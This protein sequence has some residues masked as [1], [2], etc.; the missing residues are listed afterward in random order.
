MGFKES[1]PI[2]PGPR[3]KHSATREAQ[4]I[5]A[6]GEVRR[7][8]NKLISLLAPYQP[9]ELT[10][11]TGQRLEV[12][13]RDKGRGPA[14]T[15]AEHP[16]TLL[17]ASAAG[18]AKIRVVYGSVDGQTP[19]GMSAGDVPPYEITVSGVGYVFVIVTIDSGTGAITSVT[20]GNGATVP[21]NSATTFHFTIGSYSVDGS[22]I[23]LAQSVS[24]SL[25]F[26]TCRNWYSDPPT[27]T[28]NWGNV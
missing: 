19:S 2:S 26:V 27:F 20:L 6:L 11:S 8:L 9:T 18:A 16:F 13:A 24:G 21:D 15:G 14:V 28:A 22:A 5:G 23:T 7:V 10:D 25:A 12:L 17:D 1:V 4:S 3:A